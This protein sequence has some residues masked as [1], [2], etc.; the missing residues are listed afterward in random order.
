M[1]CPSWVGGPKVR[2]KVSAAPIRFAIRRIC[3]ALAAVKGL[4]YS[5]AEY[6]A[7]AQRLRMIY[8]LLETRLKPRA[9]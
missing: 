6:M 7:R 9:H 4:R 5:E 1:L 3:G 8:D 2:S